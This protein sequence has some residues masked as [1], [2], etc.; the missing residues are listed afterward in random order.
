M[1]NQHDNETAGESSS[2]ACSMHEA[3]EA[4]MGYMAREELN[5]T[6]FENRSFSSVGSS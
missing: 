3:D 1:T 5:P 4:Y 2:P 6:Y